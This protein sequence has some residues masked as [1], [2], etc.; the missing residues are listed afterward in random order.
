MSS[1]TA[2][3]LLGANQGPCT[4]TFA[5]AR[6][7]ISSRVGKIVKASSLYT[8]PSWGFESDPF[9]NQA[10]EIRTELDPF[11]LLRTLLQIEKQLGRIRVQKGF[12]A[13]E[14]GEKKTKEYAART[15]DIDILFYANA[16]IGSRDL[17]L[18]HPLLPQR[19]FALVPLCEI[20]PD[21]VHPSLGMRVRELLE[22]CGDDVASVKFL[23]ESKPGLFAWDDAEGENI[24]DCCRNGDAVFPDGLRFLAIE[25][26][27]GAGKTSLS[28]KIASQFGAKLVLERFEENVFLPK[29]Y[30][31]R[32]RYAFPLE[33]AF[34]AERYR[35]AREDFVQE[36][37]SPFLVSDFSISK[38]LIFAQNT[39]QQDEY[40]LFSRLFQIIL[41]TVPKPDLY[42]YLH[43]DVERLMRNI[44]QRARSYEQNM[45]PGYLRMIES[46]YREYIRTLPPEK[47]LVIDVSDMD[48]VNREEDYRRILCLI[49]QAAGRSVS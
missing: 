32:E 3:L 40:A 43:S 20:A 29:F 36:L 49:A 37:F 12:S 42:V 18:P 5:L 34:L 26:N 17:N 41:T 13:G 31:D 35:Q 38:S 27:I 45:D 16:V 44:R 48:F 39:L 7:E 22:N 15:I 10:L 8:S 1:Q 14:S 21:W 47:S 46:G 19:A 30:E 24:P 11:A 2:F 4:R 9:L 28:R 6:R 33:L 23:S 25:G